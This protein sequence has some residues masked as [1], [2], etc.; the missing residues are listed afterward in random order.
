MIDDD[1]PSGS[2]LRSGRSRRWKLPPHDDPRTD[3]AIRAFVRG[4]VSEREDAD[5]K[6][7]LVG[8]TSG[9]ATCRAW[10]EAFVH[11][12]DRFARYGRPVTL[13]VAELEGLDSLASILGQDAADRLVPPVEAA[14]RRNARIADSL[15]RTGPARFVALLPE[16]D[17]VAARSYAERVRSACNSWLEAGG[18]GVRLALGWAQPIAGGRLADALRLAD[19]RMNTDRRRQGF[20]TPPVVGGAAHIRRGVTSPGG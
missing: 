17:E 14:M 16:T 4:D 6:E 11:E 19:D 1:V 20:R 15:A 5:D 7:T 12:Q 9:F 18:V 13:L 10:D 3:S 2:R 8:P